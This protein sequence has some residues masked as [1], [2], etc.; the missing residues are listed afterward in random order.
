[1]VGGYDV[2]GYGAEAHLEP[3]ARGY[4]ANFGD[5]VYTGD[6]QRWLKDEVVPSVDV[7]VGG[8]P[9][10]GFSRLGKRDPRT[11]GTPSGGSTSKQ[12]GGRG[13][14]TS[15]WRRPGLRSVGVR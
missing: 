3:A 6:I 5:V 10:Q 8:P 13:P 7:V 15:F 1:M 2:V 11:R 4:Q 14:S 9:C 12:Y